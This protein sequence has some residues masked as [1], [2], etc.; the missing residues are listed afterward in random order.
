[1]ES[2]KKAKEISALCDAHVSVIIF[3]TS[4]KMHEFSSTSY[5]YFFI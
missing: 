2:W 4:G 5:V 3:A 1:M